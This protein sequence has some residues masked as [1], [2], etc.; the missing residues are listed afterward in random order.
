M[1][2]VTYPNSTY[3]TPAHIPLS[4]PDSM[5]TFIA[6]A[7]YEIVTEKLKLDVFIEWTIYTGGFDVVQLMYHT[8]HKKYLVNHD[9]RQ[10]AYLHLPWVEEVDVLRTIKEKVEAYSL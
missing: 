5:Q 1:K 4:M 7:G 9:K 8:A 6:L 2:R 3:S 10:L